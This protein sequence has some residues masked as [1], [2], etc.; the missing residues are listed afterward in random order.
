MSLGSP[1]SRGHRNDRHS[2]NPHV[3][4]WDNYKC[5]LQHSSATIPHSGSQLNNSV[6]FPFFSLPLLSNLG[7]L[8][9]A[10]KWTSFSLRLVPD[11]AFEE[12]QTKIVTNY[13]QKELL[14]SKQYEQ[15]PTKCHYQN[16][17]NR[18]QGYLFSLNKVRR[19]TLR[20]ET[21]RDPT[22]IGRNR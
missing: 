17:D 6:L 14:S 21:K 19:W 10:T 13:N 5:I 7:F 8:W 9:S 11:L 16:T 2:P 12:T 1:Q 15:M 22:T 20:L 18:E 3:L 4:Q